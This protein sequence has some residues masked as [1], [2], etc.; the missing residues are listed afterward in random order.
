MQMAIYLYHK[1]H[2]SINM[3]MTNTFSDDFIIF[4]EFLRGFFWHDFD[5]QILPFT[6]LHA[7]SP[8][9]NL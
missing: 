9:V 4:L 5:A 6:K 1:F 7:F 2:L 3:F 8:L